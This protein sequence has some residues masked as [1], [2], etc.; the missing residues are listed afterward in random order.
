MLRERGGPH[1]GY[2]TILI[3]PVASPIGSDQGRIGTPIS[4][5]HPRMTRNS[6][7]C[8]RRARTRQ[9]GVP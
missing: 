8:N 7:P 9:R 3:S 6:G 2:K 4:T 1:E 5:R